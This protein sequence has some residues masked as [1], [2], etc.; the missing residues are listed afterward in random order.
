LR[1]IALI[2]V[3]LLLLY[4]GVADA[5]ACRNHLQHARLSLGPQVEALGRIETQLLSRLMGARAPSYTYLANET[6]AVIAAIYPQNA[7]ALEQ[8]YRRC[9]NYI[10][11]VRRTCRDAAVRLVSLIQESASR[12]PTDETRLE[13][14]RLIARCEM[15]LAFPRRP[16]LLRMP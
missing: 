11:P 16:S 13:Y 14:A 6:W 12:R 8:R 9:R 5:V 3:S 4:A 7:V 2:A 1:R 10:P 15:W